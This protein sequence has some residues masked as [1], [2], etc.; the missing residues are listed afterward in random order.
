MAAGGVLRCRRIEEGD[1]DGAVHGRRRRSSRRAALSLTVHEHPDAVRELG[2]LLGF[3]MSG[4]APWIA[5]RAIRRRSPRRRR[6][7]AG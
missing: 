2:G 4:Y 7:S 5:G 3:S 6:A 1:H